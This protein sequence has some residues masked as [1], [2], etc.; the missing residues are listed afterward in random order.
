[1]CS[2]S[3]AVRSPQGTRP[4]SGAK[5]LEDAWS[6]ALSGDSSPVWR[7]AWLPLTCLAFGF[8]TN[9][10]ML[11]QNRAARFYL[12]IKVGHLPRGRKI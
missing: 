10:A 5:D 1:M 2:P 3:L 7:S 6:H 9:V 12:G 11:F 4:H 8:A